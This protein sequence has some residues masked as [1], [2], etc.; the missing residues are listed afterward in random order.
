M[1]APAAPRGPSPLRAPAPGRPPEVAI[2]CSAH[3]FGHTARQMAVVE[4]L[5]RRGIDPVLHSAA[6]RAVVED[7]L[8]PT[9]LRP[10]RLDVGIV[11]ADALSEDVAETA[12]RAA[13]LCAD[14]VVDE[15]AGTLRGVDLAVV[16]MAPAALEACTRAGVAVVA[17][18][19][20]DWAWIYGHY[21]PLRDLAARFGD[22]QAAHP[23]LFVEPGPGLHG[24]AS[25]EPAGMIARAR[26]AHRFP[27]DGQRRVLVSFGGFGL[28]GLDDRLPRVDG[29]RWVLA[30]PM[31]A[32]GRPDVDFVP[33]V[34][35]PA[36]VG[37]VHAVFTKPGYGIHTE[38]ARAGTPVLW[39]DRGAFPEAPHL[40]AAMA[41]AGG[42]KVAGPGPEALAFALEQLWSRPRPA[43]AAAPGAEA[44][45]E[46]VCRRVGW[47]G[48][49]P[50]GSASGGQGG[51]TSAPAGLRS[52][53]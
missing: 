10:A 26:P 36:L 48:P 30:P 42:V 13:A 9:R 39:V 38:A 4:A 3:G 22:W 16:D 33:E 51:W 43:P 15:L 45:A 18:G 50:N 2:L 37:G 8:G 47:E 20:F 41:A 5:R 25:V 11:Q 44:V 17:V 1:P 29:L 14:T 31:A 23:A 27:A 32:L 28:G 49:G 40:E 6:P 34:S 53:V 12:R 35:Y 46:W 21:A 24:F 7:Y 52:S 19:N